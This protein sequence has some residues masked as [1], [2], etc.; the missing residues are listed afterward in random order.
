MVTSLGVFTLPYRVHGRTVAGIAIG[1]VHT[2]KEYRGRGFA[3]RLMDWA[4]TYDAERGA[5]L[6]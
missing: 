2:L 3:P 1:G 6:L 4:E 5:R